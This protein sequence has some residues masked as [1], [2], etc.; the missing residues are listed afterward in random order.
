MGQSTDAILFYGFL[1]EGEDELPEF[2]T[3]AGFDD[4]Y[5]YVKS[6]SMLPMYGEPG[7]SFEAQRKYREALPVDLVHHC[8][9]DYP[10]YGLAVNGTVMT[11]HRGTPI[12]L[13]NGL[14]DV[15]DDM[16]QAFMSWAAER[17][18]D[19]PDPKWI[20]CSNWN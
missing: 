15:A 19:A 18:I 12:T 16:E 11:A 13:E 10:M 1:F 8:S 9:G 4:F 14:P 7:H 17:G 5:E 2:I 20:L 6:Q 3:D